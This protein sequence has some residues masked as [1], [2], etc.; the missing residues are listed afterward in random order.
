MPDVVVTENIVGS[1]M[2]ALRRDFDV[3]FDPDLWK[4][5]GRL[6]TAVARAEALV[7]R[8]QTEVT[9]ELIRAAERLRGHL[10][11]N[12]NRTILAETL[13]TALAGAPIP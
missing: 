2:D 11:F 4:D 5:P 10:R 7:V 12:V 1:P 3:L 9:V 13:L 8:N 6:A